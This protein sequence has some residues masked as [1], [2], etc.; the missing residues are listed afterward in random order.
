MMLCKNAQIKLLIPARRLPLLG[1]Q[2]WNSDV[3][4]QREAAPDHV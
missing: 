4:P 1:A 3:I 2:D